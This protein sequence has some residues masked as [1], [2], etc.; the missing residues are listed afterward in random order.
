MFF[1]EG[2]HLIFFSHS[3]QIKFFGDPFFAHNLKRAIIFLK[4]A[5]FGSCL[6]KIIALCNC[7]YRFKI[8]I[9]Y[10]II[11]YIAHVKASVNGNSIRNTFTDCIPI[12]AMYI[13]FVLV[14]FLA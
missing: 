13:V 4:R 11:V 9:I 8:R 10:I 2:H 3:F 14:Y 6:Q 7:K 5:T 12:H 1:V